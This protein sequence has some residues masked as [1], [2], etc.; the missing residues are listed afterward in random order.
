MDLR[1]VLLGSAPAVAVT[2]FVP[3]TLPRIQ[4]PALATPRASLVSLVAPRAPPP[5]AAKSTMTP[6]T[7]LPNWSATFTTGAVTA[8]AP[9]PACGV[10]VGRSTGRTPTPR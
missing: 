10:G 3:T 7:P 4:L 1:R 6:A 2:V 9:L 8:G 5:V